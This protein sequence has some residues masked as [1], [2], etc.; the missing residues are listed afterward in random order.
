MTTKYTFYSW[1]PSGARVST[2]VSSLELKNSAGH[3]LNI[4]NLKTPISIKIP[5]IQDFTNNSR[6]H[7]V[8]VN[9]TVYHKINVTTLGMALVLKV[10]PGNKA[11]EFL[12][13]L[14]YNKRPSPSNSDFNTTVPNFSSCVQASSTS[15]N[16][17]SDPYVVF[18]DNAHV[19]K[20]GYYFI[21]I[22]IKAK[23]YNGVI[24][25]KRCLS[26][27]RSK[28]SCVQYKDAPP[29]DSPR[30]EKAYHQPQYSNG[31]ENYT[32]LAIPTA[33]LYW[34]TEL[35]KWTTAGC[36]VRLLNCLC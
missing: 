17:S 22:K 14:K 1:D 9:R 5:N 8:G 6:S 34:S 19:N 35:S 18:V 7:Y 29:T 12:V 32:M 23:T 13:S 24:R 33:C 15:V 16:C 31:D 11:T 30:Q 20:T 21:G 36:R 2:G 28:R 26:Q 25:T 3:L 4:T 27:R 10:I